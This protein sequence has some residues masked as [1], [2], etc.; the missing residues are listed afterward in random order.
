MEERREGLRSDWRKS[1]HRVGIQT[2]HRS[3][4]GNCFFCSHISRKSYVTLLAVCSY[5][6]LSMS[7]LH[8]IYLKVGQI[9]ALENFGFEIK[10][11]SPMW[12]CC[13]MTEWRNWSTHIIL[14]NKDWL[15]KCSAVSPV[16]QCE[17]NVGTCWLGNVAITSWI[18]CHD[19]IFSWQV[20][21]R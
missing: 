12:L 19:T 21:S 4:F 5:C 14:C 10:E 11:L 20:A 6:F 2:L 9:Q 8:F 13:Y 16:W 7:Q 17:A 1:Q 18:H 15:W 3:I